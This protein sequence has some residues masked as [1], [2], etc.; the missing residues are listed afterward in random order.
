MNCRR[1]ME[2]AIKW[3]YSVD[4]ALAM[5][6]QDTLVSLMNEEDFRSIVDENLFRRMDFI[7]E[8]GNHAAHIGQAA[9][10]AVCGYH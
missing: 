6:Y 3:M 5:P 7:R 9:G 10:K 1:A 4:S 2:C 8:T